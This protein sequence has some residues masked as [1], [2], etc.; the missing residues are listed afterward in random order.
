M[1]RI[2]GLFTRKLI[3]KGVKLNKDKNNVWQRQFREH[4]ILDERD[5]ENHINYIHYNPIKYGLVTN[6]KDWLFSSFHV[7]SSI[8]PLAIV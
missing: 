3:T 7:V 2:K 1:A 4:T 8:L 6:L 5:L